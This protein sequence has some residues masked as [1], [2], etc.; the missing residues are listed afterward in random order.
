MGGWRPFEMWT[1]TESTTWASLAPPGSGQVT[2]SVQFT[3]PGLGNAPI[4]P[5]A[6]PVLVAGDPQPGGRVVV[7][8]DD[9]THTVHRVGAAPRLRWWR[10]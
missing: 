5:S 7:R 10:S 2:C 4:S 8:L 6:R 1:G 3:P 9:T